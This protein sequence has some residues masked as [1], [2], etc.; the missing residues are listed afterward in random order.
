MTRSPQNYRVWKD[1]EVDHI[2]PR[3]KGD[4]DVDENLQLLCGHCNR[5][6]GSKLTVAE[7]KTKLK[8]MGMATC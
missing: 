2:V 1:L 4:Q 7:L 5:V 8:E 6:K 3:I